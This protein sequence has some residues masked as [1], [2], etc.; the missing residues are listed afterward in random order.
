[1]RLPPKVT[2][3]AGRVCLGVLLEALLIMSPAALAAPTRPSALPGGFRAAA[4]EAVEPERFISTRTLQA[5]GIPER[6]FLDSGNPHHTFLQAP[7]EAY[8]SL[9]KDRQGQPDW[10]SAL[11]N[12]SISPRADIHGLSAPQP[13]DL[14]I[15]MTRTRGMPHVRF[16]H[17]QHT[18]WLA[19]GNCHPALFEARTGASRIRMADIFRGKACG[20]CHGKVA[21]AASRDCK[22]CHN[23]PQV[24]RATSAESP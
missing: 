7:A 18:E 5:P 24:R 22:R 13:M 1:M 2:R 6:Q 8:A 15:L 20:T 11:A 12:G 16:S 17:R 19:C 10:V 21:F 3:P 4:P 23:T 9:P 14:D